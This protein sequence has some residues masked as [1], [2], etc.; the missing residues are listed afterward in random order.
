MGD[1]PESLIK[2]TDLKGN[3][4]ANYRVTERAEDSDPFIGLLQLRRLHPDTRVGWDQA[5]SAHG[6]AAVG[7]WPTFTL[8]E[9]V[10]KPGSS[11]GLSDPHLLW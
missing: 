6:E 11:G 7:G 8:F 5:V 2:I 9:A 10:K 3:S 4:I 1:V